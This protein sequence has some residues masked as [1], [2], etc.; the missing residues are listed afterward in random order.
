MRARFDLTARNSAA[1][2]EKQAKNALISEA[3]H[4]VVE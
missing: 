3:L 1:A 2:I 4:P